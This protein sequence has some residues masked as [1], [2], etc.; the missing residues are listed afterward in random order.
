MSLSGKTVMITGASKGLGRAMAEKAA[1]LGATVWAIGRDQADL[2]SLAATFDAIHP[3]ALDITAD[4][5]ADKAFNVASPD[6]LILSAGAAPKMAPV[7]ELSWQEFSTN[8]QTDVRQSYNFGRAALTKPLKDGSTVATISS[9]AAL[10]GS[11][12]SGGYAGAK[13]MQWFL[14]GYLQKEAQ[15]LGRDIR[16][17]T[18][19]PKQQFRDTQ[20]GHQASTG[21][22]ER[23]GIPHEEFLSR[24]KNAL[25][26][27][28]FAEKAFEVLLGPDTVET[29]SFGINGAGIEK[30]D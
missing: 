23:L 20:L 9:G 10:S 13:R 6:I 2:A 12:A 25:T 28:G 24:F 30:L 7:R 4:D 1:S 27:E 17:L 11:F 16:F 21:Y 26:P 15:E 5:A 3:L 8:W 29:S 18:I 22:A 19:L 14:S